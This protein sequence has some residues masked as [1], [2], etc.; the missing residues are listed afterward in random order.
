MEESI[1]FLMPV[2]TS[3]CLLAIRL[4]KQMFCSF[5]P[6]ND[7]E[8]P[9]EIKVRTVLFQMSSPKETLSLIEWVNYIQ[10]DQQSGSVAITKSHALGDT[11]AL[12]YLDTILKVRRLRARGQQ[13]ISCEVSLL[14]LQW[15]PCHV[16]SFY[17]TQG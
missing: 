1:R 12:I 3:K 11:K 4:E 2:N 14:G 13:M 6:L 7:F 9:I 10:L 16:C 17:C 8:P 5:N 15:L